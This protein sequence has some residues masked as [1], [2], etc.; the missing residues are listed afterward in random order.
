[1]DRKVGVG[2]LEVA[3]RVA[4]VSLEARGVELGEPRLHDDGMADTAYDIEFPDARPPVALEV[5]S[6]T[7][8]RFI[9][10]AGV[11]SKLAAKATAVAVNK[12]SG[13]WLVEIDRDTRLRGEAERWIFDVVA[14]KVPGFEHR[15][16]RGIVRVHH[17]PDQ[18]NQV[19][20]MTWQSTTA[21]ALVPIDRRELEGVV[22]SK[23]GVLARAVD[24]ERH[25]AV[26]VRTL[27]SRDLPW[28]PELPVEIDIVW[29][30]W[31]QQDLTFWVERGTEEWQ[32]NRDP[33]L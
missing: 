10:T 22:E 32:S 31:W 20:F 12:G 4:K 18:P 23:R 19:R 24:H 1:M 25:L 33:W 28:P 8:S 30:L 16:P 14:G 15:L 21:T 29:L 2:E 9:E 17:Y 5:T 6:L 11:S 13:G 27:P 7:D 26:Q 3:H